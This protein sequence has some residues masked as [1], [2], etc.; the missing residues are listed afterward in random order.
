MTETSGVWS[1]AAAPLP[2]NADPT[3]ANAHVTAA[4][5]PTPGGCE[6]V[7]TYYNNSR[8]TEGLLLGLSNGKWSTEET[9]LP[10]GASS[11]ALQSVSCPAPGSCVAVGSY[12]DAVGNAHC[13]ILTLSAGHWTASSSP[14]PTN[15]T[16]NTVETLSTVSCPA[17]GSCGA[18]G[19]YV[20]ASHNLL[21]FGLTLSAGSW[22]AAEVTLPGDAAT[23]PNADI[24]SISCWNGLSCAAGGVYT[25]KSGVAEGV[26]FK[27]IGTSWAGTSVPLPAGANAS[28]TSLV[29][30]VSCTAAGSCA[31]AGLY[32]SATSGTVYL[33][34][35]T[36]PSGWIASAAPLPVGAASSQSASKAFVSC[37]SGGCGV[38]GAYLDTAGNTQG[39][40][41]V[42]S[43]G[44]WTSLRTPLPAGAAT[45]PGT[46]SVE[47]DEIACPASGSCEAV[48]IYYN[49]GNNSLPLL[50]RYAT[51]KL[52][53]DK[54]PAFAT[55]DPSVVVSSVACTN[56]SS[57]VIVGAYQDFGGDL[58]ALLMN[59]SSG[60]LS[61]SEGSF[62]KN[63]GPSP[64]PNL[65]VAC[66][67]P[68]SC[69][70]VGNYQGA[71]AGNYYPVIFTYAGRKWTGVE[72]PEPS[73]IGSSQSVNS[74]PTSVSCATATSC[75][76]VGSY[77]DSAGHSQG[78]LLTL[79]GTTWTALE[80]PL[81][82]DASSGAAN[83]VLDSVACGAA[84]SCF[85]VGSY[86]TSTGYEEP[87]LLVLSAGSWNAETG[88][89]P[90]EHALDPQANIASI[91][92]PVAGSCTAV[93][94]Y[95]DQ[96]GNL[97]GLIA[98][99]AGGS[100]TALPAP[101]PANASG[102]GNPALR[103][104]SCA[105]ASFCAVTGT[106]ASTSTNEAGLVLTGAAAKW[107]ASTAPLPANARA[108]G[109]TNLTDVACGASGTCAAAGSYE[110]SPQTY[111]G[112]LLKFGGGIWSA[113]EASLPSGA[114]SLF[115]S[116][117]EAVAC[118]PPGSCVAAGDYSQTNAY[119]EGVVQFTPI[120]TH[121]S[122]RTSPAN[123]V[124]G[125]SVVI[126]ATASSASG[127]PA[128]TARFFSNKALIP[129]CAAAVLTGASP[130]TATCKTT[131]VAGNYT[132]GSSYGGD[133]QYL[134]SSSPGIALHVGAAPTKTSL[135]LSV[136]TVTYGKE[137]VEQLTV[138]VS[139]H[140]TGI[141]AGNVVIKAGTSVLCHPA[142]THGQAKC[143]LA[144][145]QLPVGSHT[146]AATYS[147]ST[148]FKA[149]ASAIETLRVV[150]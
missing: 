4:S 130:D 143:A 60:R 73:G 42:L 123:P 149:S 124:T 125:E 110:T 82:A 45:A 120:P 74:G 29:E 58:Q 6:L 93:G 72:A 79:V 100:W 21:A 53:D 131:F 127:S 25:N 30:S 109:L 63:A 49:P 47:Q 61:A 3:N 101:V 37:N 5:C 88:A 52:T 142:L 86:D 137:Q 96:S 59:W 105:S 56:P 78:L 144:P 41:F 70:A 135:V 90:L 97:A 108:N 122:L 103:K 20:D 57:C 10:S 113:A 106:Y 35:R 107:S 71:T 65:S 54:A 132:L 22:T 17:T 145:K 16:T 51:G 80:A 50:V 92:C 26:L 102:A 7:G 85:A 118:P 15:D 91:S 111:A 64:D 81:P 40:V 121:L 116:S 31:A 13:L 27:L 23:N 76:A 150:A 126:T 24:P 140:F 69:A 48:G 2:S 14:T 141:P 84:G 139:S 94:Q 134:S 46:Q 119:G 39:V 11:S 12:N 148:S 114:S 19:Y 1:I 146:V 33:L 138:T 136:S 128:G 95:R 32:T 89:L 62:P 8:V 87:L 66:G 9:P 129:G 112:L 115:N 43:G 117:D 38:V 28:G 77:V 75:A 147:G 44:T 99:L 55:N 36:G 67:A 34:L 18:A 83:P 104:V 98:T 68:G 133:V